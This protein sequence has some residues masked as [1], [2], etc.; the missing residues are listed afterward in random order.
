MTCIYNLQQKY[1]R[2]EFL[3]RLKW[4]TNSV[5]K[6][7]FPYIIYILFIV[8]PKSIRSN[9]SKENKRCS[10]CDSLLKTQRYLSI[11]KSIQDSIIINNRKTITYAECCKKYLNDKCITDKLNIICL[12]C[13]DNLKHIHSLHLSA[14]E[15]TKK[16]RRI[17]YKTKR[18]NRIRL[19][20]EIK[21]EPSSNT[22]QPVNNL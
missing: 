18:L 13:C 10:L 5:S 14:Q 4:N 6:R 22:I 8:C 12:K 11:G 1:S 7:Y 9:E 17:C 2:L 15:L 16:L 19:Q 21:E 3:F 20:T